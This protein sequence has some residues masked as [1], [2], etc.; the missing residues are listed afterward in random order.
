MLLVKCSR[1]IGED[2][3]KDLCNG[4]TRCEK[5]SKRVRFLV[6]TSGLYR[7]P[8]AIELTDG[9]MRSTAWATW[10]QIYPRPYKLCS[11]MPFNII[12]WLACSP[13]GHKKEFKESF[14]SVTRNLS[15]A[16]SQRDL[17]AYRKLLL[18]VLLKAVDFR[19]TETL[20]PSQ[21]L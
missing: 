17:G 3:R 1:G 10:K 18:K 4:C 7:V 20:G 16:G 6:A 15:S 2:S 5:E 8:V 9:C 14:G 12:P 19:D 11:V 21:H 13:R